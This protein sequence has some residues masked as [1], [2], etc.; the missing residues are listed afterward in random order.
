MNTTHADK[1]HVPA[2][3]AMLQHS[4][5]INGRLAESRYL[6][7]ASVGEGGKPAVRTVVYRGFYE[8]SDRCV[9]HTD[10][11]SE[12]VR[13]LR[14]Q[15]EVQLCWYFTRSREQYR[16]T[17]RADVV[18][19]SDKVWSDYRTNQWLSLSEPARASYCAAQPGLLLPLED[20][21]QPKLTTSDDLT[22]VS[23]HFALLMVEITEVDYLDLTTSPHKRVRF[24][25][26]KGEWQQEFINP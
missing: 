17:G 3:R 14:L 1:A 8:T 6:Q 20:E 19:G 15:P 4:L 11:R 22:P 5:E 24:R 26:G 21:Y 9:I 25:V 10:I 7:L 16:M 18:T 12:K 13:Q 23:E 2:W